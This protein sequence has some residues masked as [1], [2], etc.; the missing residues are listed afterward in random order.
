MGAASVITG[1]LGIMLSILSAFLVAVPR[2]GVALSILAL[3]LSVTSI[4]LG[5]IG[6]SKADE[7]RA[8]NA[9]PLTGLIIGVIAFLVSFVLAMTCGSCNACITLVDSQ[10]DGGIDLTPPPLPDAG[11][12]TFSN[13]PD[14][15]KPD[16]AQ[17]PDPV[18]P[19]LE[20]GGPPPPPPM[21]PPPPMHLQVP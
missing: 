18:V 19:L 13:K 2:V 15:G 17:T 4:V 7:E 20:D 8:S 16:P 9:L 11:M 6:M 5:G 14:A 21:F 3:V 12:P 10:I 1:V